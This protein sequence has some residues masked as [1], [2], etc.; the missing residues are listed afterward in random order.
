MDVPKGYLIN[1]YLHGKAEYVGG[2]LFQ[3]EITIISKYM[4]EFKNGVKR[5]RSHT[6]LVGYAVTRGKLSTVI[7]KW[8]KCFLVKKY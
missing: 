1:R 2:Y 3:A 7:R 4:Q 5:T 6:V 8:K